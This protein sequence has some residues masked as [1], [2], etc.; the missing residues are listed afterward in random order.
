MNV[1]VRP[2]QNDVCHLHAHVFC[3]WCRY[4]YY[5]NMSFGHGLC[6]PSLRS[7]ERNVLTIVVITGYLLELLLWHAPPPPPP[8]R[9]VLGMEGVK[10]GGQ[11][12]CSYD[13][14]DNKLSSF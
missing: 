6:A 11:I 5:N 3:K 9:E 1:I 7:T 13:L 12:T 8:L 14:K 10:G 2:V 4:C